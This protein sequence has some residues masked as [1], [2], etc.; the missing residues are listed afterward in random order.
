MRIS[1][2]FFTMDLVTFYNVDHIKSI[3]SGIKDNKKSATI[4]EFADETT[5]RFDTFIDLNGLR[6]ELSVIPASPGYTL[7]C[8]WGDDPIEKLP[9][10]AW[11]IDPH[12]EEWATRP[13]TVDGVPSDQGNWAVMQPDGLVI[14]PGSR[15]WKNFDGWLADVKSS[16]EKKIKA[17]ATE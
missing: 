14:K 6:E 8:D 4:I 15:T 12:A 1:K 11:V 2:K 5:K 3:S 9:I 13:V 10:I 16:R 7:V 17:A